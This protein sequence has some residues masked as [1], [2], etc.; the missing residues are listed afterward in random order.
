MERFQ[1]GLDSVD[2]P[3][4]G[5]ELADLPT[6]GRVSKSATA[7]KCGLS[8]I[9]LA[10]SWGAALPVAGGVGCAGSCCQMASPRDHRLT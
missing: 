10:G 3:L 9:L 5:G 8:S 2:R 1:R 4:F 7:G 6:F